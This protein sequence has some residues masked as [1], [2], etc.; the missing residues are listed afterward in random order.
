MA[1]LGE[2]MTCMTMAGTPPKMVMRSRSMSSRARSGSKWCIMTSLPPAAVLVTSTAWHPVAWNRGTDSR[3]AFWAPLLTSATGR[4]VEG[5][6]RGHEEQAHQVGHAVA[7]GPHRTLGPPRRARRVEDGG[8]GIGVDVH[9]REGASLGL[10]CRQLVEGDDRY[11][12][13][14]GRSAVEP[15]A[16][17][18][19][20]SGS[21]SSQHTTMDR[22][23]GTSP[24]WGR[25]RWRRSSSV[26]TTVVPES[27][28]P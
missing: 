11:R 16:A 17:R 4:S 9:V 15:S 13:A 14:P 5:A 21:G 19:P 20:P 23:S 28:R 25:I 24:R 27:V 7:M 2:S 10:R 8:V 6:D 12:R 22:T 1:K 3:L 18:R 26:K